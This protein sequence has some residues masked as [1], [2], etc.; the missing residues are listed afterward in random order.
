MKLQH[1]FYLVPRTFAT[2]SIVKILHVKYWDGFARKYGIWPMAPTEILSG[3]GDT[4]VTVNVV[5]K[6]FNSSVLS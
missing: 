2:F 1:L 3:G 6:I 5:L 4:K